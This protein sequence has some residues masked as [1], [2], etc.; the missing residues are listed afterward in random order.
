[1]VV[2]DG[3]AEILAHQELHHHVRAALLFAV[4]VNADDVVVDDV[5]GNPRLLEK[6]RAGLG[7]G[8]EAAGLPG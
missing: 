3:V 5:G 8:N 1:M 7:I 2:A 4:I 6:S